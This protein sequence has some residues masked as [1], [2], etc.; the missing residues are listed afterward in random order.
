MAVYRSIASD[1]G[2]IVFK[3]RKSKFLGFAFNVEDLDQA[4]I[5]INELRATFPD[6]T[7]IC[8]A[9]KIGV[10]RPE[11]R[12]N[13]DGEPSY[14]AGAPIF[15]QIEA[16][17]LENILLCVVRYFGGT[18]LGVGGLIHAYRE[19]AKACLEASQI[20]TI[21]PRK[22]LIIAFGYEALD[23]VMRVI[24]QNQLKI[25]TQ[26]MGLSCKIHLKCAAEDLESLKGIFTAIGGVTLSEI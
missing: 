23:Q 6:A 26:E 12:M 4:K 15:G 16:F 2:P 19:T 17:K 21:V 24:A 22:K 14:S 13:D 10:E 8:Y 7:H 5:K 9:Y 20:E 3:E 11:I 1:C 25:A 18:K